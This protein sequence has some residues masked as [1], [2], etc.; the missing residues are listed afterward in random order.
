MLSADELAE[1]LGLS[2][3]TITRWIQR[4]DLRVHRLGRQIRISEEDAANFI[5]ARRN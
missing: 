1:R 5:A 4:G 3:K 2:R